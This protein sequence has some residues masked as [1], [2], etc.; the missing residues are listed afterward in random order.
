MVTSRGS[1]LTMLAWEPVVEARALALHARGWTIS[2]IARHLQI[3]RRTVRRYLSGEVGVGKRRPAGLDGFE[4]FVGYAR[5]RLL[6]DPHLWA[7]T[8]H[9]ELLELGYP[10]SYPSLT[11]ALRARGLRP[12]CE[13]CQGVKGRDRAI[14]DHPAGQETQWDWLELPDPP[15]RWG[16]GKTAHLLVG[17]LAHSSRWRGVLAPCEDQP[18][19][20]EALDAVARRLGGLTQRWRF[21]R[22]ATVCHPDSGAG[23][24]RGWWRR[25]TT[26]PRNA[27][28]AP[29]PT[30]CPRPRPRPAWT[31]SACGSATPA[32]G[33]GWMGPRPRWPGW[34]PTRRCAR[35]PPRRSRPSCPPTPR[36]ARRPWSASAATPTPSA[37]GWPGPRSPW[38]TGWGLPP[39][40][41]S[42]RAGWCWPGTAANPTRP[43]R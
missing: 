31:G 39:S 43:A 1:P 19:L 36:S 5:Q 41:S 14:I 26:P 30:R 12:H 10:G 37:Q 25:P 18:H 3:N 22:M 42:P 11:R 27:G 7:S 16:W 20:T 34:P 38:S 15:E 29:W 23:T 24:A 35:C 33:A 28:G 6:D 4:R 40:T 21:D 9:D 17:S 2:A 32:R 8:L 13:P